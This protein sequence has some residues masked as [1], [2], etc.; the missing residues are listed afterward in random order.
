MNSKMFTILSLLDDGPP[1]L[2]RQEPQDNGL[3]I[4]QQPIVER[5]PDVTPPPTKIVFLI[6]LNK[7]HVCF[8]IL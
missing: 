4:D 5:P 3:A 6:F 7:F 8:F 1:I 2:E